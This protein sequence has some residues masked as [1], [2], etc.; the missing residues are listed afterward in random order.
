MLAEDHEYDSASRR[1]GL[2][3]AELIEHELEGAP[4]TSFFFQINNVPIFCG[5]SN[6]IPADSFLPRITPQKYRDW[7][8]LAADGNQIMLRVWGG[9][10]FEQ[11]AFYDVCD[12]LGVLVWQDFL[13]ACGNYPTYP[14]FLNSVRKEARGNVKLLRHHPSIVLWAGNNEDYQYAESEGLDYDPT[15]NNPDDWLISSFSA[16][17]IYEKLLPD[18]IQELMPDTPYRYG[19]PWGGKTTTDQTVGDLHQWNGESF[20]QRLLWT[21]ISY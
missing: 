4:G 12:E 9:G 8:K 17:Y 5:G 21:P 3:R 2:R 13:F 19:S 18:V 7:V 16:R 1:F 6:W 14:L 10:I 11:Q 15:D 20:S